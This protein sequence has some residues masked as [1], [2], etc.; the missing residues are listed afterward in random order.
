MIFLILL[1]ISTIVASTLTIAISASIVCNTKLELVQI[2]KHVS[3]II[4]GFLFLGLAI[5]STF[6]LRGLLYELD[7]PSSMVESE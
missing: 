7:P 6:N 4:V 3:F 2:Q 1:I 5:G